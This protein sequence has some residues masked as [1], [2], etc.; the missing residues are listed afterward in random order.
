MTE[1]LCLMQ[2]VVQS[3]VL[4]TALCYVMS[5]VFNFLAQGLWTFKSSRLSGRNLRRYLLMQGSAMVVNSTVMGILID[6]M[7]FLLIPSQ[8]F[9]TGCITVCV[10]VLS[11][12][13]VYK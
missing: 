9:V 2:P 7:E 3:T 6:R 1:G 5:M 11:R 10:Y 8:I 4:L 13:W 12:H